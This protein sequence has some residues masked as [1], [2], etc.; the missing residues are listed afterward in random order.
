MRLYIFCYTTTIKISNDLLCVLYYYILFDTEKCGVCADECTC[1][2]NGTTSCATGGKDDGSAKKGHSKERETIV[3]IFT[4]PKKKVKEG[5]A[6]SP[7]SDSDEDTDYSAESEDGHKGK[8]DLD[9]SENNGIC[10]YCN[11]HPC[12]WK[13]GKMGYLDALYG[14]SIWRRPGIPFEAKIGNVKND[15]YRFASY[16]HWYDYLNGKDYF[17]VNGKVRKRIPKCVVSR[18]RERY[19]ESSG[20]YVGFKPNRNY[21]K[22]L[23]AKKDEDNRKPAASGKK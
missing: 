18:I 9:W 13:Q 14:G 4:P 19:P 3:K 2:W 20:K 6:K 22:N 15:V 8:I 7:V 23:M 16:G 10:S 5:K 11:T 1:A 12:M 21:Y 17:P